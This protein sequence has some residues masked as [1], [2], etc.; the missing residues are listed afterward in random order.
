[1][2][3][4]QVNRGHKVTRILTLRWLA[5]AVLLIV[6]GLATPA[7]AQEDLLAVFG[8]VKHEESNKKLQGVRGVVFQDGAEFDAISTDAR[9]GYAFDLPLRHNY[10]FS[11]EL[12]EHSNKRIEVDASG[13]P[14]DVNGTRNMDLDMSMMPLPPGF[15]ASIFEDPYGRGEYSADQN[16]VVFDG[17]YTVQQGQYTKI[18]RQVIAA[19][20]LDINSAS[21]GSTGNQI[22]IS[23]LPFLPDVG[24]TYGGSTSIHGTS[25]ATGRTSWNMLVF[26]NNTTAVLYYNMCASVWAAISP[27][28]ADIGSGNLL[29]VLVYNADT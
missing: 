12:A 11:F 18:G 25:W 7:S 5:V 22:K 6:F 27:T 28:Y 4:P 13:I 8:T 10:T 1:M 20:H 19:L 9:G 21:T 15:D 24:T 2:P 26:E 3:F 29:T 14:L 16:T 17:N 23:G